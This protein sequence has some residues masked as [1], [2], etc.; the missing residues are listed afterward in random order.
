MIRVIES[1]NFHFIS[2][3]NMR[4]KFCFAVF[5]DVKSAVLPKGI[6]PKEQ[7]LRIVREIGQ[8]GLFRKIN[9]VGGEPTLCPW[10]PEMLSLA[11]S[12]GLTTSIVTNGSRLT[13]DFLKQIAPVTDWIGISI[14]SANPGTNRLIGRA[15]NGKA[16]SPAHYA[17][18]AA[19]VRSLGIHLKLNTVVC[20]MN[21]TED[22]SEFVTVLR[23]ERWKLFQVLPIDGQNNGSVEPLLIDDAKYSAF[24]NRHRH[25]EQHGIRVIPEDNTTMTGSY[26]M[27]D[28][29]G[30]FYDNTAGRHKYSRSVLDVGIDAALEDVNWCYDK[31][32]R[33]DGNYFMRDK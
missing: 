24:T 8:G 16:I 22:M 13:P 33:R 30:R 29:A 11:K 19:E 7:L 26:I 28:P 9:F 3:C 32:V 18:I 12:H 21:W 20:S 14:D 10:L 27:M 6:L 23:P 1:L 25:L 5:D 2:A 17:N 15:V 31:F 4:C